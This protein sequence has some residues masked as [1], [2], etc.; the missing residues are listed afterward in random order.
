MPQFDREKA[1]KAGYTD[2]QIN[3]YLAQ[4]YLPE[5]QQQ[6]GGVDKVGGKKGLTGIGLL[7]TIPGFIAPRNSNIIQD[8]LEAGR[9]Q[10]EILPEQD[11]QFQV[12]E[13]AR[14]LAKQAISESDPDKKKALLDQSRI[15]SGQTKTYETGFSPDIEKGYLDR[16]IGAGAELGVLAS[17]GV[18]GKSAAKSGAILGGILGLTQPG[19][20]V[21]QRLVGGT[22]GAVVG[23]V[24]GKG[25]EKLLGIPKGAAQAGEALRK[26]V[27]RP[28]VPVSPKFAVQQSELT[29]AANKLG[30]K[31]SASNQAKQMANIYATGIKSLDDVLAKSKARFSAPSIV[32]GVAKRL[33]GEVILDE[34]TLAN[35]AFN[36]WLGKLNDL[37]VKSSAK[38]LNALKFNLQSELKPVYSKLIKGNPLTEPETVKLAFRDAIDEA[39]KEKVKSAG[40]IL[41]TLSTLHQ[42]A[43][44][45]ERATRATVGVPILGRI[46]GVAGPVQSGQDLLG[47]ILQ[48]AG[49][50]PTPSAQKLVGPALTIGMGAGG[51][52]GGQA[53][54]P[55][56]QLRSLV[57]PQIAGQLPE[58]GITT[59]QMQQVLLSP[60]I[61]EKTKKNILAAYKLQPGSQLTSAEKDKVNQA[62]SALNLVNVLADNFAELQGLGLTAKGGGLGRLQGLLG[63]GAAVTQAG[64]GGAAAAAYKDTKDAFLSKLSRASGEKGVLTD[65][66]IERISK[67]LPRFTD[68]PETAA[69]KIQTVR[70][71]IGDAVSAKLSTYQDLEITGY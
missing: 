10:K 58:Q 60:E 1:K 25:L 47:R 40:P 62:N 56:E 33:E 26:G 55:E 36:K 57:A 21:G 53:V 5:R 54:A 46:P 67:A 27:L 52:Q 4:K 44:G 34:G 7:D 37:G 2:Q 9:V 31:G 15:L 64:E 61:S 8:V 32:S 28:K 35:K 14:A 51:F 38:K 20:D 42:L 50:V 39:I 68:S 22:G 3:A 16:G 29:Q 41:D 43:P 19:A 18:A 30:L 59:E 13:R 45:L 65:K 70:Q 48:G 66:D 24:V 17:G 69:R 71:I 11:K 6:I 23:G 63:I 12:L 49:K